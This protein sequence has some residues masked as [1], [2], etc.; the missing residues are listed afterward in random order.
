M[1]NSFYYL[2]I[3]SLLSTNLSLYAF[4]ILDIKMITDRDGL[5]QNTVRCIMQDSKG[6]MWFGTINGLN[7]YNGRE[8]AVILPNITSASLS[9]SDNRIRNIFE[10][11]NGYIWI[12]SYSNVIYCYD[13]RLETFIDNFSDNEPREFSKIMVASNGDVW[14]WDNKL[15][16]CRVRLHDNKLHSWRI[17]EKILG[18][19]S[20]LCVFEDAQQ[21]IWIGTEKSIFR[22]STNDNITRMEKNGYFYNIQENE[23]QLFFVTDKGIVI[24]DKQRQDFLPDV[25][26]NSE[27][28]LHLNVITLVDDIMLIATGYD[29]YAFCTKTLTMRL[30]DD[31]F[32]GKKIRNAG[33]LTDNKGN[34]WAFNMSGV[35]WQ[36]NPDKQFKAY[37]LMPP[38]VLSSI[39]SERYDVWHDSRNIIWITTYGNGLFAIDMN[40][41]SQYHFTA[42]KELPTNSLFC[43]TEDSS[44]EIWVGT[45][46][47]GVAK[48]SLTKHPISIF[49]PTKK[50]IGNNTS[51]SIRLIY[52]D[53]DQRYWFGTRE[54]TLYIFDQF[55]K[56]QHKHYLT[57]GLPLSIAEDSL[58]YKWV[59]TKGKGVMVYPPDGK[60]AP[61]I[62]KLDDHDKQRASSNN[63]FN[64]LRDSKN[65]MWMTS[66]GSG[67][68]LAQR[69]NNKLTF[70]QFNMQNRHQDTMRDMIQDRTGLIWAGSNEGVI[71]FNPD[72]LILDETKFINFR[73]DI[74]NDSALKYNEVKTIFE[75]AKG[76]IWLGTTGG[77]LN[78]LM[79]EEPIEKSW[80]KSY[81]SKE[82]LSNDIV[83]SIIEDNLGYIWISTESGISKFDAEKERFENFIF[84][85][86]RQPTLF[87]ELSCMKKENGELM[88]GS[89]NGIY[90]FDPTELKINSYTPQVVI[91]GL[92]INGKSVRPGETDSPLIES[93]STSQKIILKHYQNSLNLEF[94]ML[95][96]H[97][98]EFNRYIYWLEN[99]ENF[100]NHILSYNVASYRNLDP[101]TYLFKVKGAN[102]FGIWN[103][104]ETVLQIVI[105]PPWWKSW[106][107]IM[108]YSLAVF[109][110]II[111]VAR[112]LITI[113]RLN[114]SIEIEKQL[115]EYKL[116]FFTN[117]SHEFRTPLTIIRGSIENL[118][119]L[120][121][122]PTAVI[123]KISVLSKSSTRLLRLI[124]QLL[125]FR[126]LQ[127]N[128]MELKLENTEAVEFFYD[129]FLTFK[130]MAERK[131][132]EFI[133]DSNEQEREML[134]DRGKIDKIAYNL[135]SNA[136]KYT[137]EFG[138]ILMKLN[139]S[140]NNDTLTLTIDDNGTG[141]PQD[142][143]DAL[144]V[145]FQ[146]INYNQDG[147]GIGLHLTSEMANIHKGSVTYSD[148]ELGGARFSVAV[149]L[150]DKNYDKDDIVQTEMKVKNT[151][152][153][154][155]IE[156]TA[157]EITE[158][159]TEKPFK[160]YKLILIED[161]DEVREFIKNQLEEY[162]TVVT[163]CNGADGLQKT[164]NEQ[165]DMVI[166]DVMMPELDGYE[167]T[168]RLKTDF[169]TSHIPVIML[170]AFSSDEHQLQGIQAG[171]DA[172]ITKPFSMKRLMTQIVKLIEQREK[173]Q[174][175]FAKEPGL[176]QSS[177]FNFTDHDKEFLD[178]LHIIIE[179]NFDNMDFTISEFAQSFKM[180]RTTFYKKVKGLTGYSPNEYLRIIRL[181]K[182]A[183]LLA[184]TELNVSEISF[185]TGFN[186]PFYF[187]KC[188]RIQFGK[189]PTQYRKAKVI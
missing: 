141:I 111:F 28:P 178:K 171:A 135:L 18:D 176:I 68:Y 110:I 72:E 33:F 114:M 51:N 121:N 94:A 75:D 153:L 2:F 5:S 71:V 160:D 4:N 26:Y 48:I 77:G 104:N 39:T 164:I 166:C 180:G 88:F 147:T 19:N 50:E 112:M 189:A 66:F 109:S 131:H 179:N 56:E 134:L 41:G 25:K 98:P 23:N 49:Y 43:V 83:L 52:K 37:N 31:L 172:Y 113:N 97:A 58:K 87:N 115:T 128:K 159:L 44:G 162:F 188:F 62:Y 70:R 6:F 145:R 143:R 59:G 124:D 156:N 175:K 74:K 139:F 65:R 106:W 92:R 29:M 47:R 173:M 168:K 46:F 96:F 84:S 38:E 120:E 86:N 42:E 126:R 63:I 154:T 187:S 64:V 133:F 34:K 16:C 15:G 185:K 54:G 150:S 103:D 148:S 142:K 183:E 167:V 21:N 137:P 182:A 35:L 90:I 170:T 57:D 13:P 40:D 152:T 177:T 169:E 163:A 69:D 116:R 138:K 181:K 123:R 99:Y 67:L 118:V 9:L 1:R 146:Q 93:I 82:G 122:L 119:A 130:E 53:S 36:L 32:G 174:Q 158:I 107:A 24:F 129:I 73:N 3:W 157:E 76:R 61:Q 161:N 102:S 100:P 184:T 136:F 125:E 95:N 60:G 108:M 17:N 117:I 89:Y 155:D 105:R 132:I 8:F 81:T 165:P 140:T 80:F 79:R 85:D 101:G 55:F 14:L 78:L 144:F 127:N 12:R 45:G 7:R 10:D 151:V 27:H 186:E 22:L 30:A 11:K 20:V 149:P 91:T